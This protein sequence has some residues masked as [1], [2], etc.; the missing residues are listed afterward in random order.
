MCP[1]KW[2]RNRTQY[3]SANNIRIYKFYKYSKTR[4]CPKYSGFVYYSGHLDKFVDWDYI[5]MNIKIIIDRFEGEKAVLKTDDG[6]SVIWPKNKLPAGIK[7]G[8]I[9]NFNIA[10]DGETEK[11]KRNLAK[12]ILNEI[13]GTKD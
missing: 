13:I 3:E 1:L 6:H 9:L 4:I 8:V 2:R 5:I 10:D 12:E 11:G 7:E